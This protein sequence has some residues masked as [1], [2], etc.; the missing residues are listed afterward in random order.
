MSVPAERNRP[1]GTVA[2]LFSD[3]VGSTRRWASEEAAMAEAVEQHD[4]IFHNAV[5]EHDGYVFATGGDSFAIAFSTSDQAISMA[6]AVQ[7]RLADEAWSTSEP[8]RVRIG[9]NLGAANERAG[10]YFGPPVNVAARVESVAHAGQIVVTEPVA[11]TCSH[12]CVELGS[13]DLKDI[14]EPQSLWQVGDEKFPPLRTLER[15]RHSIP[16]LRTETFGREALVRDLRRLLAS[17]RLVSLTGVG[18]AGKTRAAIETATA[19]AHDFDH[20]TYFA[21]LVE[22]DSADSVWPAIQRA[23]GLVGDVDVESRVL[24]FLSERRVLLVLDNCEQIIDEA[25]EAVDRLWI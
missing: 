9:I 4:R 13:H 20:G 18:G 12:P 3:I 16:T 8:I 24:E 2:F 10:D 22:V 5:S 15:V 11:R 19:A 25:A 14:S 17:H 21:D 6:L 23:L 1:T 7:R